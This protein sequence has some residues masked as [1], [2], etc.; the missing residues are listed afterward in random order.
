MMKMASARSDDLDANEMELNGQDSLLSQ[1]SSD[2]SI[3]SYSKKVGY[4]NS[5]FL[6]EKAPQ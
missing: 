5:K 6:R 2:S 1:K 3:A 4:S